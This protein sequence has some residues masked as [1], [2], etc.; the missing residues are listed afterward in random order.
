MKGVQVEVTESAESALVL[1]RRFAAAS[2]VIDAVV[3]D[4]KLP[5]MD[6]FEFRQALYWE[7]ALG[8]KPCIL[9]TAY[10]DAGQRSKA[11]GAGFAAYLTKPVRRL[12]LLRALAEACGRSHS[13]G[14]EVTTLAPETPEAA[15]DRETALAEG[16]LILVAE[17]NPTNQMVVTRQLARLGYAAD[18]AEDGRQA[19]EKFQ[20]VVYGL[21]ITD[22]HMPEMD[23]F[24][25]T[26]AIRTLERSG[27]RRRVPILAL[28]ANVL[29]SEAERCLAAG[30]D[31][32]L[33]KPIALAQLRDA[34]AQWL[35]R[36]GGAPATPVS[37]PPAP[38]VA[39]VADEVKILDLERM[40]EIFGE[41]DGTAISLLQRY[42]ES[43]EELLVDIA[44]A[45]A[46][47]TGD[48]ARRAVHSAKGASRSAGA[49]EVAMLCTDIETAIRAGDW[50]DAAVLQARLGP[51]FARVKEA[52]AELAA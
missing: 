29:A 52:V 51:A 4:L 16:R 17:D 45:V 18:L 13:L 36:A 49:D 47:R 48:E 1:L 11:L 41:I 46:A 34:L 9:L 22:I 5:G 40:R 23:G 15:P 28:T 26:D 35:P 44:G 32:H 19:L 6:G 25:L 12:T 8:V 2:I 24:E 30:M 14:E 3:V 38:P 20:S 42:V 43:T 50:H 21:V 27:A 33:G 7:P 10:D 31:D 39:V 37:P